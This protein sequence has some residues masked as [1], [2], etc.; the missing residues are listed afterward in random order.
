MATATATFEYKVRDAAG[1]IKTGKLDAESQAQVAT[2]LKSMGY[3]PISVTQ[4]NA[5][6]NKELSIPGFGKKKVKLKDLAIFSRQFATMINSGLSLLRALNILAEQT[7]SKELTRV[8]GEVRNDVETGN[9][10][11]AA[12]AKHPDVFPPLMTNMCRAGEVG[13]FLDSVLLQIAANYEAEVKLRGKVK[14]AM[15][16]PVVVFVIAVVAVIGMLLFIVPVF[17]GLFTSLGGTLPLP[18]R[19]LVTL[20][21]LLKTF[22]PVLIVGGI[23]AAITW[24]KVKRKDQ[25]VNVVDPLKLK[26]P[27][28]GG[29]FQKI[30]LSRFCRNLGTMMSSGVPILQALD[31]VADTTGNVVLARAV[32]EVQESVR[33]GEALA[34]PLAN[35]PVFPPMVVQMMAVGEDTGA[36]DSMLHKIA[37]FYDQEVEATTESLTALIEPLMIA[38][39]GAV[40]GSMIVALYMP[41][42]KIFDLIK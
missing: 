37:E 23:G 32:R 39:M 5:G 4:A 12:M 36:L 38:F 30:A 27:V 15:T 2:K 8:I 6:M 7:E 33:R 29:L 34:A 35:H 40:I 41:I 26:M 24:G 16:Y 17:A 11:S 10:L 9:S 42:F 1:K 22:F 13:G 31:I 3:A 28:F 20:S 14:S 25:V 18:T 21:D 19:I